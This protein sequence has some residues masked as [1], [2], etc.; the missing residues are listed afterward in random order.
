MATCVNAS[1]NVGTFYGL[2][3]SGLG[4]PVGIIITPENYSMTAE[5]FLLLAQHIIG[6]KAKNEFPVKIKEFVNNSTDAT[7]HD[8]ADETRDVTRQGKYRF[9]VSALVNPCV[10]KEL[11]KF[12]NYPGNVFIAY[13][14]NIILGTTDDLGA[15]IRGCS[16]S[17]INVQKQILP[18]SDGS[19]VPMVDIVIDLDDEKEL[20][21]NSF[22]A[23]MSWNVKKFDGLTPVTIVQ[24]GTAS[25]TSIVV[26]V[27]SDC[28]G[29][30]ELAIEDLVTAD[31]EISGAGTISSVAESATVAGRYTIITVGATDFTVISLAAAASI[32][33]TLFP[34]ICTVPAT[35][36][37]TP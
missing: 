32:S 33:L 34:V 23:E 29:G 22:Q 13:S 14:N 5:N 30:C 2:K 7:Y 35:I 26:D 31:F 24:V 8:F 3:N 37:V 20:S 12:R 4:T 18:I 9:M 10:K 36:D 27:Y 16:T 21:E 11:M 28:N 19:I 17:M 15:T 1:P 6:V 25:A